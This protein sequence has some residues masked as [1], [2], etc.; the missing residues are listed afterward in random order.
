[1]AVE[2][3]FLH[4]FGHFTGFTAKEAVVSTLTVLTGSSM[5]TLPQTLSGALPLPA[6][7]AF[8]VFTLLYT[9]CVAA[10]ATIRRE[11]DSKLK[12]VGVVIAQCTV[13]WIAAF[14]VYQIGGWIG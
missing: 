10:V 1:M 11:L 12:T 7:L 13:A 3:M 2:E 8:L 5:A 6:A 4:L 14:L 9:P